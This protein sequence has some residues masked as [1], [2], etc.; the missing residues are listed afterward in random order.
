MAASS[1]STPIRLSA[2]Y[3]KAAQAQRHVAE[4]QDRHRCPQL[5]LFNIAC[6]TLRFLIMTEVLT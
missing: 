2:A 4:G 3:G 6:D 5:L 1:F